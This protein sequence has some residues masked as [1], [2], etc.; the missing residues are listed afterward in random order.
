MKSKSILCLALAFTTLAAQANPL[1]PVTAPA[2]APTPVQGHTKPISPPPPVPLK[3]YRIMLSAFKP[4]KTVYSNGKEGQNRETNRAGMVAESM[5]KLSHSESYKQLDFVDKM[6][7]DVHYDLAA[8]ALIDRILQMNEPPDLIVSLGQQSLEKVTIETGTHQTPSVELDS[9]RKGRTGDEFRGLEKELGFNFPVQDMYCSLNS[10]DR[11]IVNVSYNTGDFVCNDLSYH[12]AAFSRGAAYYNSQLAQMERNN[13]QGYYAKLKSADE[14]MAAQLKAEEERLRVFPGRDQAIADYNQRIAELRARNEERFL[15]GADKREF[16]V[17]F[18]FWFKDDDR[19][20]IIKHEATQIKRD[21]A[22]LYKYEK[23]RLQ[24]FKSLFSAN[25]VNPFI[26]IHLPRSA[27]KIFERV[28]ELQNVRCIGAN[29]QLPSSSPYPW[30]D[31]NEA[32]SIL[33]ESIGTLENKAKTAILAQL[34]VLEKET[35]QRLEK[36]D[37]ANFVPRTLPGSPLNDCIKDMSKEPGIFSHYSEDPIT[38]EKYAVTKTAPRPGRFVFQISDHTSKQELD[39][40]RDSD[41]YADII[42]KMLAG[43]Y[44][45]SQPKIANFPL[46]T[47]ENPKGFPRG[48]A[49]LEGVIKTLQGYSKETRRKVIINNGASNSTEMIEGVD[50]QYE[51]VAP[52]MSEEKSA[53]YQAFIKAAL[54]DESAVRKSNRNSAQRR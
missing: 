27:G 39:E 11:R 28:Y 17:E 10:Q 50:F 19:R 14:N 43:A 30:Y 37:Q 41:Q 9:R 52:Q 46:P 12:M 22:E 1:T 13:E 49:V 53:C 2:Q 51:T 33:K 20:G 5:L 25:K 54:S 21:A 42:L 8:E 23:Q 31:M 34:K 26:F 6:E 38:K 47:L 40:D 36:G 16:E 15:R 45:A 7:L 3:K 18:D 32:G 24:R 29:E 4:W 35:K 48:R 44:S